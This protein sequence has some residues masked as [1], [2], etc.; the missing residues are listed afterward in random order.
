MAGV[1]GPWPGRR[2][3]NRLSHERSVCRPRRRRSRTNKPRAPI[4]RCWPRSTRDIRRS[5]RLPGRVCLAG[6]ASSR[7]TMPQR[8]CARALRLDLQTQLCAG[9]PRSTRES[10][11]SPRSQG[12]TYRRRRDLRSPV[13]MAWLRRRLERLRRFGP[14]PKRAIRSVRVKLQQGVQREFRRPMSLSPRRMS[15]RRCIRRRCTLSSLARCIRHRSTLRPLD[16]RRIQLLHPTAPR[17]STKKKSRLASPRPM[18]GWR[19]AG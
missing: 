1:V 18:T 15:A 19:D 17:H 11:L 14:P 7:R 9:R 10:H 3:K 13:S 12:S 5:P 2:R 4:T 8:P 16:P 6:R